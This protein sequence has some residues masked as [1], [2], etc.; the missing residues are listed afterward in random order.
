[1]IGA[2]LD[3]I[4]E[5]DFSPLVE[6]NLITPEPLPA[7]RAMKYWVVRYTLFLIVQGRSIRAE[8][9][10]PRKED[11]PLFPGVR[12]RVIGAQHIGIAATFLPGTA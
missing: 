11:L 2:M 10:W 6:D 9:H 1:V 8:A 3:T 5:L 12:T 4:I 7:S